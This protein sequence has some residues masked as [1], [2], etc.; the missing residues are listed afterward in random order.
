MRKQTANPRM[1]GSGFQFP[2]TPSPMFRLIPPASPRRAMPIAGKMTRPRRVDRA[3]SQ[4]PRRATGRRRTRTQPTAR[5]TCATPIDP[6]TSA[7]APRPA[8]SITF[9]DGCP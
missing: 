6:A 9:A 7:I 1:I 5:I 2:V 3:M 8:F 4:A